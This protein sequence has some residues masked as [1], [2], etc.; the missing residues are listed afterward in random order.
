MDAP[1][2]ILLGWLAVFWLV[3][4]NVVLQAVAS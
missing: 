1:L 4:L 2:L 3:V